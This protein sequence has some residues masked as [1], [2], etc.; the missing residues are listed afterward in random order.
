MKVYV[1][2]SQDFD[3]VNE[4]YKPIQSISGH[5]IVFPHMHSDEPFDSR[6][7]LQR[8][9]LMIAEVSYASTG[10]GIE[11]GWADLFGVE[12]IALHKEGKEPS[13]SVS[14][15]TD[16]VFPYSSSSEMVSILRRFL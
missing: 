9:D 2:H 6:E 16:N 11:L 8:C 15:V 12:I 1:A 5:E 10:L 4:L 14:A 13:A 3:F 7:F